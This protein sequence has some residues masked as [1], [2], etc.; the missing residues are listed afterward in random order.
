MKRVFIPR[1][2]KRSGNEVFID[3]GVNDRVRE[4]DR[5]RVLNEETLPGGHVIT[6]EIG[7]IEVVRV[8]ETASKCR[9]LEGGERISPGQQVGFIRPPPPPKPERRSRRRRNR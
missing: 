7:L 3:Q 6:D 1:V 4:G 9:I 2:V 8:W 5:Y